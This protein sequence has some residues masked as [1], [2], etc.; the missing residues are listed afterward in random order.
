MKFS[1]AEQN[2]SLFLKKIIARSTENSFRIIINDLHCVLKFL[3]IKVNL[4]KCRN[5]MCSSLILPP[6]SRN[7]LTFR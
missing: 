3:K 1:S 4:Q 6:E 5:A 7:F 2:T